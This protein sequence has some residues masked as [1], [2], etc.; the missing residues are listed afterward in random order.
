MGIHK[1]L[2][3]FAGGKT[4]VIAGIHNLDGADGIGAQQAVAQRKFL[5]HGGEDPGG[6]SVTGAARLLKIQEETP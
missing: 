2:Q 1:F 3:L 5:S 4:L 6:K